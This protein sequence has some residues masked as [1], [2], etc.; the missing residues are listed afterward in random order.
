MARRGGATPY[1]TPVN[2]ISYFAWAAGDQ[3]DFAPHAH[4]RG[5]ELKRQLARAS[6]VGMNAILEIEPR[7][8]FV[9][10][11]PLCHVVAPAD[12]PHLADEA[13]H[14]NAHCVH[15]AWDMI[16]GILHPE[17]GGSPR[18]LDIIGVN[19]YG[20][21]QWEHG[22]P[23][24][25]IGPDDPRHTPFADLLARLYARYKRPL[26]VS[27]T[28]SHADFRPSWLHSIGD[29]CLR[30]LDAGVDLHGLCL[31]PILD[32]F[33]WHDADA[34]LGM[35][36]WELN[37]AEDGDQWERVEHAATFTELRRF[38]RRVETRLNL[39]AH[40]RVLA[41]PTR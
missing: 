41:L 7:A 37:R 32:M 12:A 2:E 28:S 39:P 22:R 13:A 19:Y 38:Q 24:S 14:F 4:E 5:P 23:N 8:R 34:P 20:Y 9:H 21:N 11:D 30:A 3:G 27:E 29:Q 26:L 40:R 25:V 33:D 31:Y 15:E 18:H 10:C 35:G 1:Y 36:L 17:L 16:G 6:I